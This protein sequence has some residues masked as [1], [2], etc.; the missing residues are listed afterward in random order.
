MKLRSYLLGA[1]FVL[2]FKFKIL[3]LI[4][5]IIMSV[6]LYNCKDW[7][8][9]FVSNLLTYVICNCVQKANSVKKM[10][11]FK[12]IRHSYFKMFHKIKI[13]FKTQK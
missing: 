3:L 10:P 11:L 4:N 8:S 6:P 5:T 9:S 7:D 12:L 13:P 1:Y 2:A